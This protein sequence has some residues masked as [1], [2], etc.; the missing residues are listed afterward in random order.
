MACLA[1]LGKAMGV[2]VQEE[3]LSLS[4]HSEFFITSVDHN[5]PPSLSFIHMKQLTLV[6]VHRSDQMW[7]P[8]KGEW[9]WSPT[10][11]SSR[12]QMSSH[13]TE[14]TPLVIKEIALIS[15]PQGCLNTKDS[16]GWSVCAWLR[17]D[18]EIAFSLYSELPL[19][20]A[21]EVCFVWAWDLVC[22]LWRA[23]FQADG[24]ETQK[25]TPAA[26]DRSFF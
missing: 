9:R 10:V 4:S 21:E 2:N 24:S 15:C 12:E 16:S 6:W 25:A 7:H 20:A 14:C 1:S 8:A 22:H 23:I 26:R 18:L 5:L 13:A 11:R 3:Y 17:L 19:C